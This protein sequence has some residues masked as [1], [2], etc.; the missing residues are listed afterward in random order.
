M[1][2]GN[3]EAA[4]KPLVPSG[5]LG[6]LTM[7]KRGAFSSTDW[8]LMRDNNRSG[9]GAASNTFTTWQAEVLKVR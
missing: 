4:W 3:L 2:L 5:P 9:R 1:I 8:I 6:D 7:V